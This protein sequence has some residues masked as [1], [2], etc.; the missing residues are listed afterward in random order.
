MAPRSGHRRRRWDVGPSGQEKQASKPQHE[1]RAAGWLAC[2]T[3][4][5]ASHHGSSYGLLLGPGPQEGTCPLSLGQHPVQDVGPGQT[6]LTRPP[7]AT[8]RKGRQERETAQHSLA[9]PISNLT[10]TRILET[11]PTANSICTTSSDLP[12]CQLGPALPFVTLINCSAGAAQPLP[13]LRQTPI[14]VSTMTLDLAQSYRSGGKPWKPSSGSRGSVL[15][16]PSKVTPGT[17]LPGTGEIRRQTPRTHQ[18]Y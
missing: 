6:S 12:A 9:L 2:L 11:T 14:K 18:T 5:L 4:E 8:A 3:P 15:G 7:Q 13:L 1:E 16:Q 10:A 17:L